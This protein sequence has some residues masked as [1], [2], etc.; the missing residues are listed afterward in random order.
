MSDKTNIFTRW[1]DNISDWYLLNKKMANIGSAAILLLVGLFAGYK[2]FWLPSKE[3]EAQSYI[4]KIRKAFDK[5]SFA[6]VLKG[7]RDYPS[8]QELAN[9]FG[10][11]QSGKEAALMAGISYARTGKYEEA[12]DY[13]KD[14][15]FGDN[16]LVA[17]AKGA[18]AACYAEKG[19]VEKAA[20]TYEAAADLG[21][22]DFIAPYM[23]K[24]AGVHYE[25]AGND[26][27]ALRCYE[28]IAKEYRT[29]TEGNDIDKYIFRVKARLGDFNP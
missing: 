20:K 2:Y 14:A 25:D 29:T 27:G 21:R 23:L 8:A 5:D 13:L 3:K 4:F 1:S 15:D 11:T 26:K 24:M 16:F 10:G 6:V 19:D 12:I 7:G 17:S 9:D 22:N 18:L 28:R